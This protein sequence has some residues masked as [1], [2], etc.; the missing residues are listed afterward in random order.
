MHIVIAGNI[1]SG[2]TTLT[3]LLVRHYGWKPRKESV[4]DN[5]YLSDYYKDM[6]RWALN[7]EVF[8]L[9]E[10]FRDL[11]EINNKRP[12]Q[13]TVPDSTFFNCAN[14]ERI[15]MFMENTEY[16]NCLQ[17]LGP[18]NF[19][20]MG[21]SVF[22]GCPRLTVYVAPERYEDF[23]N[24]S[25]WGKLNIV[26]KS[27]Y[28]EATDD[29]VWGAYYSYNYIQGSLMDYKDVNGKKVY[30][31]HISKPDNEYLEE[32]DGE[33]IIAV[34]YGTTYNYNTTYVKEKAFMGN[35]HLKRI[36]IS[37]NYNREARCFTTPSIE[38]RDSAFA[39]CPNLESIYL[40][41]SAYGEE[42]REFKPLKPSQ[43]RPLKGVL[44]GSPKA[45]FKIFYDEYPDYLIS[46]SVAPSQR[47]TVAFIA[48]ASLED[49]YCKIRR[50][51]IQTI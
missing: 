19:C 14:L 5:P 35:E 47:R 32:N 9:K 10:R 2:K 15:D 18:E 49:Q 38:L 41:Y 21:S 42:P 51:I 11:L 45:V 16:D 36:L 40:C 13:M 8:F 46:S 25:I 44:D 1:G 4:A 28:E 27:D 26:V 48:I 17:P 20:L 37:D 30:N 23:K 34:D 50:E 39:D 33:L 12:F 43:I 6:K 7:L 22:A 24:D 29:N 3:N 31:L